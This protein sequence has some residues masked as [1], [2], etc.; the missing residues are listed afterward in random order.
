MNRRVRTV[1]LV[2]AIT[3]LTFLAAPATARQNRAARPQVTRPDGPVWDVIRKQCT[4]CHGIDDYAFY[5]M[6][7]A[8]WNEFIESKHKTGGG[9]GA[10]ARLTETERNLI[11]D[12][13]VATFGPETKPFPRAYVPPE[14]TEFFSDPEANR[15]IGRQC[16]GCHSVDRVNEARNSAQRW[17]VILVQMRE[18]GAVITDDDLER[19]VEWLAR[20]R[21]T[22]ENQ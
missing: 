19:L 3:V 8:A 16:A 5:S 13:V 1:A 10:T 20:V 14:I 11:L 18:R 9:A 2:V 12:W 4:T 21:G 17:R 22:N 6:D 15:L 7:R